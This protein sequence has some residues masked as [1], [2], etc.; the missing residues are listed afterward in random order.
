MII[1]AVVALALLAGWGA[2]HSHL[3]EGPAEAAELHGQDTHHHAAQE[4]LEDQCEST[5]AEMVTCCVAM[6]DGCNA[7]A[8]DSA[9][10][11]LAC[12]TSVIGALPLGVGATGHGLHPE[13]ETPPPRA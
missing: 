7:P 10:T 8:I 12:G 3:P 1:G 6:L 13:A 11:A 9:R 2:H 5:Q 4:C